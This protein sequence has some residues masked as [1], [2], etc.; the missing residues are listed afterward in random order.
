LQVERVLVLALV[1][2]AV[3][4]VVLEL[5]PLSQLQLKDILLQ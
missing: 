5:H 3:V 2:V 4:A 1:Q